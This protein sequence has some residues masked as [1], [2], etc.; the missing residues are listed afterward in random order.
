M[1]Y[2]PPL[3][4]PEDIIRIVVIDLP[5]EKEVGEGKYEY[6]TG[7]NPKSPVYFDVIGLEEQLN[8]VLPGHAESLL[9]RLQNFRR[10]YINVSTGEI[11]S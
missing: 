8:K 5:D 11:T 4:K 1:P 6:R 10:A 7:I 9:D 2:N 3:P